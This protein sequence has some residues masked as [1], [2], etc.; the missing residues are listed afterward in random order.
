MNEQEREDRKYARAL[1]IILIVAAVALAVVLIIVKNNDDQRDAQPAQLIYIEDVRNTVKIPCV[2]S[3][4]AL[5]CDWG[6]VVADAYRN[7]L[8]EG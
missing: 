8:D 7:S 3:D 2:V 6:G 4:T 5:S 1:I